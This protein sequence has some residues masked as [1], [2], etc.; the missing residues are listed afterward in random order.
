MSTEYYI[1]CHQCKLKAHIGCESFSGL[2][3]WSGDFNAMK[4]MRSLL[5]N[6]L[7]HEDKIGIIKEHHPELEE[8]RDVV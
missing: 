7:F 6:C 2:Q 4:S 1:C 3:F 8:Y 5:L